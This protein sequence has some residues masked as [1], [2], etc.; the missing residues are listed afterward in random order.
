MYAR[1]GFWVGE[2]DIQL[3]S[4][5]QGYEPWGLL[6]VH[7]SS[8]IAHSLLSR[9]AVYGRS[10]PRCV[11]PVVLPEDRVLVRLFPEIEVPVPQLLDF[12]SKSLLSLCLPY[13][14]KGKELDRRWDSRIDF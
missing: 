4:N 3:F 9:W 10:R 1:R 14:L 13:N 7:S 12:E 5:W 11:F 6:I 8:L 2:G